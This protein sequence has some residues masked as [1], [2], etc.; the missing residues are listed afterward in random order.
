MDRR[1]ILKGLSVLGLVAA[2]PGLSLAEDAKPIRFAIQYNLQGAPGI[3][4]V[5]T[6]AFEA[7]DVAVDPQR[8]PS[9]TVVR[10]RL[11][12]GD[13]DIGTLNDTP[14]VTAAAAGGVSALAV[15]LYGGKTNVI[16]ARPDAGIKAVADLRGKKI[17]SKTGSSA[18]AAFHNIIAPKNGLKK[19][20]YEIVNVEFQ[21]QVTALVSGS[22]DAM[23]GVEPFC[24]IAEQQG[25]ASRVID[26]FQ[27]DK[28][29]SV[30]AVRSDYLASNKD[31][32]VAFMK[33]WLDVAKLF[34]DEPSAC[35]EALAEMYRE[36]GYTKLDN[37]VV[38]TL[39]SRL[40]VV[41]DM[42]PEFI[43]GLKARAAAQ[44]AA[45]RLKGEIDW[46]QAI[47]PEILEEAKRTA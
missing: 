1:E 4:A 39:V 8:F 16:M 9:G 26:Y 28:V 12:A 42:T 20:D 41:P 2:M 43:E 37:A 17:A 5:G 13:T 36:S 3:V 47:R 34:R 38:E 14:F 15:V 40:V 7:R 35:V 46:K 31:G 19:D 32:C 44:A 45:G 21:D 29:P 22:V 24:L 25:L 33:A 27:Y 11:I 6:K 23:L 10:D 18:D 30:L